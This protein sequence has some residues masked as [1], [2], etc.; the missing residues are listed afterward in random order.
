MLRVLSAKF[1]AQAIFVILPLL[2]L[3]LPIPLRAQ[4]CNPVNQERRKGI[5]QPVDLLRVVF[6]VHGK[7]GEAVGEL[8]PSDFVVLADGVP[9]RVIAF[10]SLGQNENT[11][12]GI[13]IDRSKSRQSI[14]PNAEIAPIEKFV[15]SSVES[16]HGAF[17]AGFNDR[18]IPMGSYSTDAAELG[19]ELLNLESI[20]PN[21][22]TALHDAIKWAA[23][24][25][26]NAQGYRILLIVAEGDDNDSRSIAEDAIDDVLKASTTV[27]FMRLQPDSSNMETRNASEFTKKITVE[28]GGEVFPVHKKD[29]F[30]KAFTEF[31][32][33]LSNLYD[34]GFLLP[35]NLKKNTLLHTLEIETTRKNLRVVAPTK[36]YLPNQQRAVTANRGK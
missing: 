30:E 21:G 4:A 10:H 28:T 11:C 32:E 9:Q 29:D 7:K 22:G 31:K 34:I 33:D 3:L 12:T 27:Y 15:N 1:R 5:Y 35:T 36:F 20:E 18:L 8:R 25:L 6:V 17:L 13:V 16:N 23:S 14:L 24:E 26:A 19:R 2:I